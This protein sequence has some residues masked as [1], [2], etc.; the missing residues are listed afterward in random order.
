[1]FI[2]EYLENSQFYL[3]LNGNYSVLF[4][5]SFETKIFKI[6]RP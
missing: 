1:M 4:T 2:N 3:S 6:K 5:D